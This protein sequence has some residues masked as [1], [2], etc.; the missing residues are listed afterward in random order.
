M[1]FGGSVYEKAR[2][3]RDVAKQ[4]QANTRQSGPCNTVMTSKNGGRYW[5]QD[6]QAYKL[7]DERTYPPVDWSKYHDR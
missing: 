7:T 5:V 1:Y 6:G 4:H 3:P 2:M